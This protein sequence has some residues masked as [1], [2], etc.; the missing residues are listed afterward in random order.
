MSAE[1]KTWCVV[2]T[3]V[4]ASSIPTYGLLGVFVFVVVSAAKAIWLKKI[5][6]GAEAHR[7]Q[8]NAEKE[9]AAQRIDAAKELR[10][11]EIEQ[12]TFLKALRELRD[13]E[14]ACVETGDSKAATGTAVR[15]EPAVPL[16]PTPVREKVSKA[17]GPKGG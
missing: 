4:L 12:E 17:R 3:A 1:I 5:E 15:P 9:L 8:T 14:N 2:L 16:T 13:R 11:K 7:D 6:T 10:R